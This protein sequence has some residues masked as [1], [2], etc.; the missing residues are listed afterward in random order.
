MC[1]E[2]EKSTH[3][4]E[5]QSIPAWLESAGQ[6]VAAKATELTNKPF[7]AFTGDRVADLTGDQ[8]TGFQKLRDMVSGGDTPNA[9][10]S[11]M[12]AP[13]SN[14]GTERVVDEGGKLGAIADYVSPYAEAA[15]NPALRKIQE[16]S[17][18]Q[19]KRISAGA[20]SAQAFGD[21]RHGI[22]EAALGRDTSQAMGDTASKFLMDAINQAMGLRTADSNRFLDTAKTNAGYEEK[23]ADR[24]L[25]GGQ[26]LQSG[27][28]QQIQ[29]LLGAGGQ[30]QLQQQA[31]LDSIFGEFMR[32]YG[33]DSTVLN[34]AAKALGGI[35]HGKS[36]VTDG[37]TT[38][39]DNSGIAL[40]GSV[41]GQVLSSAPVST[42]IAT[43]L[44][45]M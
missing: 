7:E 24:Q 17:D 11:F 2:S 39:P 13:A 20:T 27:L 5:M 16:Q 1:K 32:E 10:K 9:I 26:A 30:Q 14:V 25:T 33:H 31:G 12:N 8:Q 21:A 42:A 6:N 23:A 41:G 34:A 4:T 38:E 29:A 43:A 44:M 22:L 35:P 18:A 45:A 15:L 40:A 19:R 36:T 3:K 28:L 37:T